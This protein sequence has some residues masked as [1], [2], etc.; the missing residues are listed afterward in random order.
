M[1]EKLKSQPRR[2]NFQLGKIVPYVLVAMIAFAL[3]AKATE[4]DFTFRKGQ[5]SDLPAKLDYSSVDALYDQ[6][7]ENYDGKLTQEQLLDGLKKGLVSSTGDPY[8]VYMNAKES[9]EFNDSLNGKF[10]GIGAELGRRN[11]RLV[12]IAP[13][14]GTPAQRAG[15]RSG[16]IIMQINDEDATKLSTDQAVA[17]IRGDK[18]T[19][20]KLK[21]ARD[22]KP[23]D[24]SI[25][26]EE[27]TTPSV[28]WSVADGVGYLEINQFSEDTGEL[29]H[30]AAEEFKQ[31]GVQGVVVDLRGNGGGYLNAA[32]DVASLWLDKKVVVQE[33]EG[34]KVV[35]TLR[36]NSNPL[37][38]GMKTT[39]LID[40][41]S[42]SASEILAG[43]LQD[44]GV[45]KLIGTKS[46]GKGSVQQIE[47][48]GDG[49]QL[50]VTVAR[51]YTPNNKNIDKEGINPDTEVKITAE[52]INAGKDPQ[53]DAAINM[54][55]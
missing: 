43:A 13:L 18:G 10:S 20:V 16:D 34:D 39:V 12:V 52:D 17:K 23:L 38:A 29:A 53:K 30:R 51:W 22:N 4:F 9:K 48:L 54:V 45:A 25:V 33:K 37:L 27:I 26:R 6:L 19:T 49:G 36:T 2:W 42:A 15:L 44:H 1:H 7:R 35:D 55:K 28:K 21:V 31:K 50:K 40:G 47:E 8:T 5:S 14:D 24:F 3:G 46:F 41:G 11:D 32:V